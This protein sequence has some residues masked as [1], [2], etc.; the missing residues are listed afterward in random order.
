MVSIT[1]SGHSRHAPAIVGTGRFGKDWIAG[2]QATRSPVFAS[3]TQDN[4]R[5]S[6]TR[7]RRSCG[8]MDVESRLKHQ[9]DVRFVRDKMA[10]AGTRGGKLAHLF[11]V[12]HE[13]IHRNDPAPALR[14]GVD[15]TGVATNEG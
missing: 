3:E 13:R 11:R 5:G 15:E 9:K 12:Q 8:T 1:L 14:P 7:S 2:P 6:V 4:F 10:A